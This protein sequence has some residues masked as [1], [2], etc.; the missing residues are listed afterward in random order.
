[1]SAVLTFRCTPGAVP[2]DA[3]PVGDATA[4][5]GIETGS[6]REK[7]WLETNCGCGMALKKTSWA[8]HKVLLVQGI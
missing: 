5:D 6:R 1:M 3:D 8:K 7:T 4:P 2:D